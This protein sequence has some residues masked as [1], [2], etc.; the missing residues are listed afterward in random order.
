MAMEKDS[1]SA[2]TRGA[3]TTST[4]TRRFWRRTD[5]PNRPWWPWG[6]LPLL[7]LLGLYLWGAFSTAPAIERATE[8]GVADHLA[9]LG[10]E[11]VSAEG[12][13]QGVDVIVSGSDTSVA[14]LESLAES[15]R[16]E[17]WAGQLVCPIDVN[18]TRR[19]VP[20]P[21][22]TSTVTSPEPIEPEPTSEPQT[23]EAPSSRFHNFQ[24]RKSADG[25]ILSGEVPDEATKNLL[26][27]NAAAMFGELVDNQL[28]VSNQLATAQY[29]L[30]GVRAFNVLTLLE[31]GEANWTDGALSVRGVSTADNEPLART[32]F[33][34]VQ[35]APG[36]GNL[37]LELL[38]AAERCNEEF[39]TALSQATINFRTSSAEIDPGSQDL[40]ANLA[41]LAQLC[42]GTLQVEGHTDSVGGDAM[43]LDLSQ[44]RANSV[45]QALIDYGVSS[46]RLN[47]VGF[48]ESRPVADN[49]TAA[50]RA[51][52]RR[53]VIQIAN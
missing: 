27:N 18:V 19:Q 45:R 34:A 6:L 13:G 49:G 17:T 41:K 15:A 26:S 36:L 7:G 24:F 39:A 5:Q 12:D 20:E 21:V 3:S 31:R 8:T 48:G 44:A 10:Y 40:L 23:V 9:Q 52:N 37:E 14:A 50:G 2:A 33:Q 28:N 47:A 16:C 29:S 32:V 35:D 43:N 46:S 1:R 51:Q 22:I 30:A 42:P 4:R 11:A 38:R 53:I 25:V